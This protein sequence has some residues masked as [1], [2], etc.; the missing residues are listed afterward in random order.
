[1]FVKDYLK[2][3]GLYILDLNLYL[4]RQDKYLQMVL[5]TKRSTKIWFIYILGFYE[6]KKEKILFYDFMKKYQFM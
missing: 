4:W 3:K 5:C 1:M 6:M 2:V